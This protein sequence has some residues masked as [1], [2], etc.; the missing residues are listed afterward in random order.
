[1]ASRALLSIPLSLPLPHPGS[2][3]TRISLAIA[4][5][6]VGPQ[7]SATP[8]ANQQQRRPVELNMYYCVSYLKHLIL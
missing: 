2:D 5:G 7:A 6:R 1:M 4:E 3:N 8:A